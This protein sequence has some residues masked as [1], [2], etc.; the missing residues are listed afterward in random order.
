MIRNRF[1][2]RQ[3]WMLLLSSTFASL[4]MLA[5]VTHLAF[6]A[7]PA[8]DFS[9]QVTP[10]PLFTTLKPGTTTELELGIKNTGTGTEEL[11]IEPHKFKVDN[12]TGKVELDDVVP[13]EIADWIHFSAPKFTVRPGEWY[14]QKIRVALPKN[15]GF[16][17]SLALLISRTNNPDPAKV[18]G[19]VLKGSLAVFTLINVDR[20]GAVRK[21]EVDKFSTSAGIYEYLPASINIKFKNTGNTIVQPYGNVFIQQNTDDKTSLATLPVNDKK[22]YILPGSE[23]ILDTQ[24]S[25][26]FPTYQTIT[27]SDGSEKKSEAWDWSQLSKFRIGYYTAKLVAVYNDGHRDIPIEQEVGFWV[28]PWK[29]ILGTLV[30]LAVLLFGIWTI[31]RKIWFILLRGRRGPSKSDVDAA[32]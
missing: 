9:L 15:T 30:V 23:R 16:S 27:T 20:P 25:D 6:A 3:L 32:E 21:L 24:W 13:S 8:S 11:K 22:G 10:S 29:I 31:L 26:G 18:S 17:Y 12:N 14:T 28:L 2:A 19:R 7:T 1:T 5:A 4:I